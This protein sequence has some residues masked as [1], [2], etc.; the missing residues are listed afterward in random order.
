MDFNRTGFLFIP[1]LL[2]I[3][4]HELILRRVEVDHLTLPGVLLSGVLFS[5]L[6]LTFGISITVQLYVSFWGTLSIWILLYRAIWHPL[7][8][9]PGPFGAKLSKLWS[10]KQVWTSKWHYHIVQ[11]RLHH[12]YGDYVRTGPRE[13]TI[14]DPTAI[15]AILG[16]SSV[17]SKGPFYDNMETSLH[18]TRDK[19]FHRQRRRIWDNGMKNS[20]STFAP[21]VEEFTDQLLALLRSDNGKPVP[22]LL[23]C[24]YY[25]YDVMAKLA[26]DRPMG[27][28][29]GEQ[30]EV[31]SSILSTFTNSL[32]IMGLFYH[33]PWFL[34]A[35]GT[36]SSF[37]GPMK[38][39]RDWSV[40]QMKDRMSRGNKSDFVAHLI[41]NTPTDAAGMELLFGESRLIISAGTETTSSALTFAMMQLAT[42]PKYM[43][44]VRKEYRDNKQNYHCQRTIPMVDA[45][46]HESMRLWSP[47]FLPAQRV[48][49][50]SGI[51]I[52]GHFIPGNMIVQMP[53]FPR[54]RDPRNFVR[55]DE[56][57]PERWTTSPELVLDRNAATPFS[58]GPYNCVGQGLAMMELRS[59]I[60]RVVDEF[61][62]VLPDGFVAKDYWNGV[63]DHLTA[64]P[65]PGQLVKFVPV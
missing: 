35:T 26:F 33:I 44:A 63:K 8:H 31:A 34:K 65:P 51:H 56:F 47:V 1:S 10:V 32:D 41:D 24:I 17:T 48:T 27:F 5:V 20:L 2:A 25:S 14:F 9:Y 55:P 50:P 64:G 28:M 42:H 49:P 12:E 7:R 43:L 16:Y 11:Q 37:A 19:T 58:T 61:D 53:P 4:L 62:I 22:L 13:L 21:R 6:T 15:Q 59:V 38:E 46:I 36:L 29:K 23:Y 18:V 40:L 39:W 60:S 57:L 54:F 52:N 45:V 3:T 30:T